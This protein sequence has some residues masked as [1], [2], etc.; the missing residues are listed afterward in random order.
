[1]KEIQPVSIWYNGSMIAATLFNM[2]S[3]SD[4]LTDS[5]TFYYQLFSATTETKSSIQLAAGNLTMTG[6]DYTTYSTSTSSN[7]YAYTWGAGQLNI[8]LI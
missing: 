2:S 8:T 4:N 3:I 1:M 6:A 7:N 5:A